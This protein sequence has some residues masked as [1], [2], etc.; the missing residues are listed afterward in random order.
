MPVANWLLRGTGKEKEFYMCNQVL[1]LD[2]SARFTL[3]TIVHIA[4]C[5][6]VVIAHGLKASQLYVV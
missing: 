3:L 2:G 6:D 4:P 1:A 5:I